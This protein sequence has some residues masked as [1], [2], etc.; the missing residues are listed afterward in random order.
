MY[1]MLGVGASGVLF[2]TARFFARGQPA[3]MT[4]EYQE[5]SNEYLKVCYN[6]GEESGR[7]FATTRVRRGVEAGHDA[8]RTS[9]YRA[10][11]SSL[12]LVSPP[13]ATSVS[14]WS[15]AS[16]RANRCAT[17]CKRANERNVVEYPVERA[18]PPPLRSA[19]SCREFPCVDCSRIPGVERLGKRASSCILRMLASA[20]VQRFFTDLFAFWIEALRLPF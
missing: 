17:L 9:Y 20:T 3:T 18:Q 1:V 13:R 19:K 16:R 8:N 2:G 5:A 15:R 12:S 11:R 10:R 4:K 14:V 7:Y 6:L